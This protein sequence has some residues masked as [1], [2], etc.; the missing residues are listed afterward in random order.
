[1]QVLIVQRIRA[2]ANMSRQVSFLICNVADKPTM[3]YTALCDYRY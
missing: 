1:L 2:Y 3:T